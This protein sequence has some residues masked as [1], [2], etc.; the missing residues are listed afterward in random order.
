MSI[1]I[2]MTYMVCCT[3]QNNCFVFSIF[4]L[5]EETQISLF[6]SNTDQEAGPTA[7]T[8]AD[9]GARTSGR[10]RRRNTRVCG[11]SWVNGLSESN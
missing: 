1:K 3:Y 4:C 11:P 5:S 2:L 8:K 6:V 7:A 9:A 10:V